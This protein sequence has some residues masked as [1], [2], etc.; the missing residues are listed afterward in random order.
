MLSSKVDWCYSN[1]PK[2]STPI[3]AWLGVGLGTETK[4]RTC[5][6]DIK[7]RAQNMYTI[8]G[9]LINIIK[10]TYMTT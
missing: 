6:K 7:L 4:K 9:S 3:F 8:P 5:S 2:M 1:N 10:G